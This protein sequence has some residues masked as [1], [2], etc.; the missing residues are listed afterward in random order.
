M[1][2][3][4]LDG[5]GPF[6][7]ASRSLYEII[8]ALPAGSV[9]AHFIA[10]EGT[11]LPF[12]REL[13]TDLVV[14]PGLTRFD[15]TR[16]SH[17]RGVRW[18]VLLREISHLPFTLFAIFKARRRWKSVDLI[19]VNEITEIVP[20]LIACRVFNAPLVVHVRSLA[21][22]DARSLRCRWLNAALRHRAAAVVAID[23]SVRATLPAD[24]PVDVIHNSFT[25]RRASNTDANLL[26][27]L[28]ALRPESLK[29]GFIGNLHHA[30]GLFDLLE[31]A[32]LVRAA[33]RDVEFVIVGGVTRPDRGLKA[34]LLARLGLAQDVHARLIEQI[35]V[36]G[37]TETFH[38]L[39]ATADIQCVYDK[40]D[41]LC[42]P[43]HFDAPGRPIF[44]AAFSSVPC[45]A[46]INAPR[47]DTLVDG[48]TGL[49]VPP[50]NPPKLAD[51]ILHFANRREEVGRMGA[52]ARE[53]ALRNFDPGR[54]AQR[55]L[56]VYTRIRGDRATH[57]S[58]SNLAPQS[59]DTPSARA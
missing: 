20:A 16:Y 13:A 31:A 54:N 32:K 46:A 18:L 17:Y 35:T 23:E 59:E 43:S 39:G 58:P 49:A 9:Q 6:G 12:Y 28:D 40:I 10:V 2:V 25:P 52:H 44:E 29:I 14:V 56:A 33:G 41:V 8:R 5:V 50:M 55:L 3:L 45:I 22:V 11:V 53:L 36:A 7:G 38:L 27:R 21:R 19:H 47:P 37:L 1:K 51:A 26:A 42:F 34:W 30:K 24:I 48:E 15:N 4:Y 57:E